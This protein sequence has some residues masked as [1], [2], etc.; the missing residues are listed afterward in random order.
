MNW[1]TSHLASEKELHW[2][3]ETKVFKGRRGE[4]EKIIIKECIVSGSDLKIEVDLLWVME[5]EY[6]A[7]H[8]TNA[9]QVTTC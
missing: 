6:Q 8:F 1:A 7:N 3:V 2:T 4:K 9:D 5:G